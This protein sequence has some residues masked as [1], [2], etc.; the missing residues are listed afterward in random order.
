MAT[1]RKPYNPGIYYQ[2]WQWLYA[3]SYS[4]NH[5]QYYQVGGLGLACDWRRGEYKE[6]ENWVITT[7]GHR[8]SSK[9]VLNRKDKSIGFTRKNIEWA[10][11]KVRANCNTHQNI[12][13]KFRNK[14]QSLADWS[15]ELNIPYWTL[16]RRIA[17]GKQLKEIVKEFK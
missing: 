16:R 6:F 17:L 10:T 14:K 1:K 11:P 8:P 2:Q 4:V 9:Y 3:V 15:I 13:T 7:I 12:T 5:P